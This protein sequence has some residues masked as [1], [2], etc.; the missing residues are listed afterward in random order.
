MAAGPTL[1]NSMVRQSAIRSAGFGKKMKRVSRWRR[2][3][4]ARMK[5]EISS[6]FL[7]RALRNAAKL[8]YLSRARENLNHLLRQ[9]LQRLGGKKMATGNLGELHHKHL[10]R[11]QVEIR[12]R[13][14]R[15]LFW[16]TRPEDSSLADNEFIE[17]VYQRRA[18]F[19][20]GYLVDPA[21]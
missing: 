21:E 6:T 5:P 7:H 11:E 1:K 8:K 4:E 12:I 18:A 15:L 20:A 3:T 19:L 2:I 17:K 14:G 10:T 16:H 9:S 13:L